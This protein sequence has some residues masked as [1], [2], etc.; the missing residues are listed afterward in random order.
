VVGVRVGDAVVV[1]VLLAAERQ[2]VG[3]VVSPSRS[4]RAS[5]LDRKTT[6]TELS[7]IATAAISGP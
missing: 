3:L 5:R 7:D 2:P 4:T 6:V 1:D